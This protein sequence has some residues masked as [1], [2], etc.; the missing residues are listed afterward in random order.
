MD[1]H[2]SI[3]IIEQIAGGLLFLLVLIDIFLTVLYARMG[4]GLLSRFFA[5]STWIAFRTVG[6]SIDRGR[7]LF[8][9]FCGPV[10]LILLVLLWGF[11]LTLGTA[12]VSTHILG[13][14]LFRTA[15]TVN[16][17]L[18]PQCTSAEAAYQ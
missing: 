5:R 3:R 16:E 1:S 13:R 12:L 6:R 11:L 14:L 17:I 2:S 15:T 8:L 9:S 10:I 4:Y 18:S 7:S